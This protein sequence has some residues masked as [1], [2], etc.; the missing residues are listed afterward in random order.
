MRKYQLASTE[1]RDH[2]DLRDYDNMICEA[3]HEVMPHAS[4]VVEQFS[5]SV[6]PSPSKGEAIRI[7]RILSKGENLGSF[8]ILVPKL[9]FSDEVLPKKSNTVN[10]MTKTKDDDDEE[11]KID[12]LTDESSEAAP[13][14]DSVN[15][16]PKRKRGRPCGSKKVH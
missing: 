7:G 8:C 9:F 14:G 11:I 4:V 15:D 5:Y 6:D 10:D 3:V 12:D 16:K 1:A 2:V 13:S